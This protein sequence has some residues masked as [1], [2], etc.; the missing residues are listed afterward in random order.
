[1]TVA[2][3][4]EAGWVDEAAG[5]VVRPYAVTHGRTEPTRGEFDFITQVTATRTVSDGDEGKQ[6]EHAAILRLCQNPTSVAEIAT[7]LDLPVGTVRVLLGDLLDRG[8]IRTR[9]PMP[10]GNLPND[11]VFKAVLDG[12]RAL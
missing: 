8:L 11:H 9:A 6:P 4:D 7:H 10:A 5:P 2:D 12:L 1:M 3:A